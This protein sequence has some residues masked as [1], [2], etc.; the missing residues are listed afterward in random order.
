MQILQNRHPVTLESWT[1][2]RDDRRES[3]KYDET[4]RVQSLA[5]TETIYGRGQEVTG[6]LLH[7]L[8]YGG[9]DRRVNLDAR[10]RLKRLDTIA[11]QDVLLLQS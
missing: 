8:R 6:C 7:E 11:Q 1:D 9:A 2:L 4:R 5:A 10:E 3:R